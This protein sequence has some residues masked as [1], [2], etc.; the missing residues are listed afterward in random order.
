[1]SAVS[2]VVNPAS[3][4]RS[5]TC[6]YCCGSTRPC[7]PASVQQPLRKG[8]N[9]DPSFSVALPLRQHRA[10]LDLENERGLSGQAGG[11][12]RKHTSTPAEAHLS[13]PLPWQQHAKQRDVS[14]QLAV[15]ECDAK[16]ASMHKAMGSRVRL[17]TWHRKR[18]DWGIN[19]WRG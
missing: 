1:M 9:V 13:L 14:L 3:A 19:Q 12:V 17:L 4:W 8:A 11:A 2:K 18:V 6:M 5:M 15:N 7:P 10:L 16:T